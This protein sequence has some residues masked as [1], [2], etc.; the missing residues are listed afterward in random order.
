MVAFEPLL[1]SIPETS[2]LAPRIKPSWIAFAGSERLIREAANN[3][4][5]VN[6]ER[7]IFDVKRLIG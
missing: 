4:L 1:P 7:T 2:T 3:Q 6:V 5:D